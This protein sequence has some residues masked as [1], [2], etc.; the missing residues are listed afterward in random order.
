MKPT[1]FTE[2]DKEKP[3]KNK[4]VIVTNNLNAI[5]AHGEMSHVWLT[6]FWMESKESKK[7]GVITF[8]EDDRKII[9]LSHWKYA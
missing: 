2:F 3:A 4:W 6:T 7:Q 9:N 5:N 1:E 8:D